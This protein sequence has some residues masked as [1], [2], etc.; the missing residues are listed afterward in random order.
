MK[1]FENFKKNLCQIPKPAPSN[2]ASPIEPKHPD[3]IWLSVQ[4][5]MEKRLQESEIDLKNFKEKLHQQDQ[6]IDS[7]QR[8]TMNP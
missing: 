4:N 7:Y 5:Y 8:P 6:K 1:F 3:L 2:A